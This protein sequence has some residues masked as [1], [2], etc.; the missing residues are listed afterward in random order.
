MFVQ[1][2]VNDIITV[3]YEPIKYRMARSFDPLWII[4]KKINVNVK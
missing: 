1:S 3:T 2:K 4:I